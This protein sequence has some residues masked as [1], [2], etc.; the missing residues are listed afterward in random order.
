MSFSI[1]GW[2]KISRLSAGGEFPHQ[3]SWEVELFLPSCWE[4]GTDIFPSNRKK[5]TKKALK[6]FTY[7]CYGLYVAFCENVSLGAP[8][9]ALQKQINKKT[10]IK[11]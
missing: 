6:A 7:H 4:C 1:A 3:R 2:E 11:I 10:L 9:Y 5:N 8:A